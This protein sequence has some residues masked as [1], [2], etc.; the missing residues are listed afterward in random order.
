MRPNMYG[1]VYPVASYCDGVVT[2]TKNDGSAFTQP[3]TDIV[4]ECNEAVPG[5]YD[6][7]ITSS[8]IIGQGS[9]RAS[10]DYSSRINVGTLETRTRYYV[11]TY[12]SYID[13]YGNTIYD[14]YYIGPLILY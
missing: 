3:G 6:S 14:A 1:S 8:M 7:Q 12:S 13:K 9:H 2:V 5:F 4:I 10:T 11:V